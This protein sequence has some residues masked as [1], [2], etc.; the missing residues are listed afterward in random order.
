M[1][2]D[3]TNHASFIPCPLDAAAMMAVAEPMTFLDMCSA[4][5]SPSVSRVTLRRHLCSGDIA[6]WTIRKT[7]DN[8]LTK[9]KSVELLS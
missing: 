6:K 3:C 7:A 2:V 8:E 4:Q 9:V 5:V 1:E